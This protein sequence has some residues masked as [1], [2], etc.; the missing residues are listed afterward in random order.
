MSLFFININV[1]LYFIFVLFTYYIMERPS[2][3]EYFKEITECTA[4]RSPCER[5][6][7]GCLLV[8]ENC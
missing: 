3:Q 6:K 5:L 1:S 2:W 4:K 7:V 8:K